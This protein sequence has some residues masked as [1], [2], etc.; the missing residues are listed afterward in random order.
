[1]PTQAA[2][3]S[4]IT[5]L[6]SLREQ[7][8]PLFSYQKDCNNLY[9]EQFSR[10]SLWGVPS[11]IAENGQISK[12]CRKS[13]RAYDLITYPEYETWLRRAGISENNSKNCPMFHD[14]YQ[15]TQE[16]HMS[17]INR[18]FLL[19]DCVRIFIYLD[20]AWLFPRKF[21]WKQVSLGCF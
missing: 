5:H 20:T 16:S 12:V 1:M 19:P 4:K 6:I 7:F 8:S 9:Q 3:F 13:P 2:I 10:R 17:S 18:H 11:T 21:I 15:P 14:V